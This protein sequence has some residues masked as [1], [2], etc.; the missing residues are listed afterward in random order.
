M[1]FLKRTVTGIATQGDISHQNTERVTSA[2]SFHYFF[3]VNL[4]ALPFCIK[5]SV[6]TYALI[7]RACSL[8]LETRHLELEKEGCTQR[9]RLTINISVHQRKINKV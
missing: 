1:W 8:R 6:R 2:L 7:R 5:G 3:Y 9:R 4:L